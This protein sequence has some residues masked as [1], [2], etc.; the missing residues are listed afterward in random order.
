[1]KSLGLSAMVLLTLAAALPGEAG[2]QTAAPRSVQAAPAPHPA[3][4]PAPTL[5]APAPAAP[6][7]KAMQAK[8][9][10]PAN[11][12]KLADSEIIFV[13]G[14]HVALQVVRLAMETETT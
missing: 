14:K 2:A 10:V 3:P 5:K 8:I 12:F 4:A 6:A 7:P 9:L 11:L 1:M 13:G